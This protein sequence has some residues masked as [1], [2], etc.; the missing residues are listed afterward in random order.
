M[1]HTISKGKEQRIAKRWWIYMHSFD[2]EID[3]L[4]LLKQRNANKK[5]LIDLLDREIQLTKERKRAKK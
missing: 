1:K 4:E 2:P 5:K 3:I